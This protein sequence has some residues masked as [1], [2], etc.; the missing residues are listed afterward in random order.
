MYDQI[1]AK[2][3][4]VSDNQLICKEFARFLCVS[5]RSS[6]RSVLCLRGVSMRPR[7]PDVPFAESS[8][9]SH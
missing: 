1:D 8:K 9:V 6:V 7:H 4:F 2:A 5:S 3:H